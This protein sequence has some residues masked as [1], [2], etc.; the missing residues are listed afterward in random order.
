MGR[1]LRAHQSTA[2]LADLLEAIVEVSLDCL[3]QLG[4]VGAVRIVHL[5]QR[6][7]G[8]RFSVHQCS[9]A[10]RALDDAVRNTHFT[11]QCRQ[12]DHQHDRINVI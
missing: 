4:Q 8:V 10:R 3:D 9:D 11:A 1:P 12:V 2:V 7:A 5:G 6:D